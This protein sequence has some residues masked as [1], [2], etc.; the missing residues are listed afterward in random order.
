MK[1][2]QII[3]KLNKN[4]PIRVISEGQ[5]PEIL[6]VRLWS[7]RVTV[8]DPATLYFS[9]YIQKGP[10]PE[11]CI[12]ADV[13]ENATEIVAGVNAALVAPEDYGDAFNEAHDLIAGRR[14]SGFYNYMFEIANRVQ[15][16]DTLIDIAS[17]SFGASL[18]FIDRDFRILSYSTQVPVTDELWAQN[19]RQGFCDYEFITEV[20][21]LKAIQQM[22][23]TTNPVEVSCKSSPFRKLTS[24]VYCKDA[25]IGSILL[26]EG[27][28]SY[29]PEHVD[30][31]RVL[32]GVIGYTLLTYSPEML[33]HTNE[34]HSF[35]SNLIIG[36]PLESQPEAY[37]KLHFPENMQ[38]VYLKAG[39]GGH[40]FPKEA[41]LEKQ[42]YK[43]FPD[44]HLISYRDSAIVVGPAEDLSDR[45]AL[46]ECFPEEAAAQAG[47]SN[48]FDHIEEVRSALRDAKDALATGLTL[49]P[50]RRVYTFEKYGVYVMLR[51]LS[52][53]EDI[54]RYF[55]RA[56]TILRNYDA[57]NE[58]KLLETLQIY[59]RSNCNIKDTAETLFMHRNS[60]IYRLRKIGELCDIDLTDTGTCFRL[61]QS[62]AIYRLEENGLI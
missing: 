24:R 36:A 62:F 46:L 50:A 59:L 26:I 41:D 25:W 11:N 57:K 60:V 21:K 17:Q 19:I 22:D 20:R 4:Y 52:E 44:C 33:Y 34:F 40:R 14:H 27:E 38:V 1:F 18:V 35:L 7:A 42:V 55:H 49:S 10:M 51:K 39:K 16:V 31:L 54:R 15:S 58:T 6:Q 43:A 32:S 37:R 13:P 8:F 56:I 9:Y 5:D 53:S 61:R 2:R 28:D 48:P 23:A 47:V 45:K 3:E 30:M 29:R 12:F